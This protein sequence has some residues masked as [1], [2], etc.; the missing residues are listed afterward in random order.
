MKV[1]EELY[2]KCL[3]TVAPAENVRLRRAMGKRPIA[4]KEFELEEQI[5]EALEN[6]GEATSEDIA[7]K[8]GLQKRAA[9]AHLQALNK[10]GLL[11]VDRN[12]GTDVPL[13]WSLKKSPCGD[14]FHH[15]PCDR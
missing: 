10:R 7:N 6:F 8:L 5:L 15:D 11:D 4:D 2:R 13:I 14:L 9:H 12:N 3:E 1:N